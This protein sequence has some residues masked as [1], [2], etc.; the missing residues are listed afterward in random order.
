MAAFTAV[1]FATAWI[2][3]FARQTQ[4][5]TGAFNCLTP[6]AIA[7][8]QAGGEDILTEYN[9]T[10]AAINRA[11]ANGTHGN[12]ALLN[13]LQLTHIAAGLWRTVLVNASRECSPCAA[14]AKD[15]D[16]IE[17]STGSVVI[18]LAASIIV[19]ES[20]S[21]DL[22]EAFVVALPTFGQVSTI[23]A[24]VQTCVGSRHSPRVEVERVLQ[25]H[26]VAAA[27]KRSNMCHFAAIAAPQPATAGR[28]QLDPHNYTCVP[29]DAIAA[30][31]VGIPWLNASIVVPDAFLGLDEV[32]SGTSI[33]GVAELGNLIE[34]SGPL[35][36]LSE[37]SWRTCP[38]CHR[39]KSN[40]TALRSRLQD[41]VNQINSAVA[42][43]SI[44]QFALTQMHIID[45]AVKASCNATTAPS[46]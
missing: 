8:I 21:D 9:F 44:L 30:M 31:R 38:G 41:A 36:N 34:P 5:A 39:V 14:T 18:A 7:A 32:L 43:G 35:A 24:T 10:L 22:I 2:V 42:F 12:P 26:R 19:A 13:S 40:S 16:A 15:L 33:P 17:V 46:V 4:A 37:L 27:L 23:R 45:D 6:G 25:D 28:S 20:P 29:D 11:T 1:A 3:V